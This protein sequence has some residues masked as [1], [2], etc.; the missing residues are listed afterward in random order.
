MKFFT[1]FFF[2]EG[3]IQCQ[4][5]MVKGVGRGVALSELTAHPGPHVSILGLGTF[6]KVTSAVF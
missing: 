3:F 2:L 4:L 1:F 6:V 5:H